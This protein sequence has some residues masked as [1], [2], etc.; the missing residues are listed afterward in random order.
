MSAY[1][2]LAVL[3]FIQDRARRNYRAFGADDD[4]INAPHVDEGQCIDKPPGKLLV[5]AAGFGHARGVIVVSGISCA[6]PAT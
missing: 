1:T 2:V 6:R 4:V 5:R 3:S